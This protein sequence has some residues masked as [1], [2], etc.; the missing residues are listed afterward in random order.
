MLSVAAAAQSAAPGVRPEPT[1]TVTGHVFCTDTN[2]PARF[3]KVSLEAVPSGTAAPAAAAPSATPSASV[4]QG[5][6]VTSHSVETELDGSFTLTKVKPGSYYVVVEKP[7]YI[8]A[9]DIFTAK[10]MADPDPQVRALVDAALPRVKV[11]GGHTESAEVRIDRGAAISGT[12]LYDDGSPA[13]DIEVKLLHKD[14][15][16]KWVAL[17]GNRNFRPNTTTDDR[18]QFR[19]A[20][21]LADE[22]M[23]QATLSLS[24]LTTTTSGAGDNQM[25][26]MMM[27][28][29]FSLPFYGAGA[30]RLTEA[31]SIKLRA[32]QELTGQDMLLPISKLHHLTGRVA[33]GRDAHFV[34]AAKLTL[35]TRDDGK[36][37]ATTEISRDDGLFHFE[38][39]PDGDY[40]L[41]VSNAR[42]VVWEHAAPDPRSQSAMFN[43]EGKDKERV[44]ASYGDAEEPLLLRG[45]MLGVTVTVPPPSKP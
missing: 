10:Q 15:A 16:G 12:L 8:K 37:L 30:T 36:E 26:M 33:A 2:Q 44:L 41:R 18:G 20:S 43:P 32:G 23:V 3:A 14:A 6:T 13:A 1:G 27:D 4:A 45:E 17:N 42:D 9:R 35:V 31:A 28:E 5:T 22:Y 29:R 21:L 25:E 24:N 40:I 11:E 39:V 38:F 34:N 19:I 7:G